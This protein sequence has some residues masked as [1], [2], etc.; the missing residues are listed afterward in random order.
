MTF[1]LLH[2]Q[3]Y[4]IFKQ[5]QLEE[6]LLRADKRNWLIINEGS[7]VSI[8]LGISGKKEELIDLPRAAGIPIIRRFSGGGT[9]I[10]NEDTLFVTC[11]SQKNIHPFAAYPEPILKWA[12]AL[13]KEA[14]CHPLFAL[15]END[16]VIGEKKCGGNAQYIQ[17]DRWLHH[18]SFL[19]NFQ[20]EQMQCLLH[21]KKTPAYRA[22]R[23]H[24]DFLCTLQDQDKAGCIAR[25]KQ[26][27]AKRFA[28]VESSLQEASAICQLPHRR[29]TALV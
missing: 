18:T 8:V 22:G 10:V 6:A 9:V 11:I 14:I 19:W 20:E 23:S 1:H 16:F 7:P 4:P 2:L 17:R 27:L 13:Y 12:E 28:L 26:A 5:L 3:G 21:P 15:R 24:T 25:L 29:A